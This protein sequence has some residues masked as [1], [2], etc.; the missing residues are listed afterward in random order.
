MS[1]NTRKIKSYDNTIFDARATTEYAGHFGVLD[2]M[3][4]FALTRDE[5][6]VV[7]DHTPNWAVFS[8]AEGG[9]GMGHAETAGRV[10]E[11]ARR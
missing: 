4:E 10:I 8:A 6:L 2:L 11:P 1:T 5:A 9:V 7:S 3:T